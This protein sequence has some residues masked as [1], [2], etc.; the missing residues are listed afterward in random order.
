MRTTPIL[1]AIAAIAVLSS[2]SQ[3]IAPAAQLAPSEPLKSATSWSLRLDEADYL[4]QWDLEERGTWGL[5][6]V[7]AISGEQ[8]SFSDFLRVYYPAGSA[9]PGVSR[10][11]DVPLGGAG[12]RGSLGLPPTDHL[13]LS[14]YLRFSDNFDFVR[15]GK[16]PGIYGGKGNS[17]GNIPDGT[18]GFSTR[19][20]WREGGKGEVYA[21]LPTSEEWGTSLSLE[22]W[23]FEPGKWHHIVQEVQLNDPEQANGKIRSWVD[24]TLV[25]DQSNLLFRTTD[26]LQIDGIFF[27]TFFG[28]GDLSWATPDDVHTD[29]AEF[30]VFEA[31]PPD[32]DWLE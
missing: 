7:E 3:G 9:S 32:L 18:D 25:L 15:G 23:Q 16:L 11:Y 2:C 26:T 21:Y 14:Y 1:S 8:G 4:Q 10:E 5:E 27:S 19:M 22:S 24:G 30:S 29:F 12:F 28:G 20:M 17:G 6:N 31:P 13:Y